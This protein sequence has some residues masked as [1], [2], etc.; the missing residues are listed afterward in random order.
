MFV[1]PIIVVYTENWI[2]DKQNDWESESFAGIVS[3]KRNLLFWFPELVKQEGDH[4]NCN[5]VIVV[6]RIILA[7]KGRE[8]KK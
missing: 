4:E 7:S 6:T 3:K 5:S 1:D 2:A 8:L